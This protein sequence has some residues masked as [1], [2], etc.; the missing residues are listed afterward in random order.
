VDGREVWIAVPNGCKGNVSLL[1]ALRENADFWDE[2]VAWAA[3]GPA[4]PCSFQ[5]WPPV[6]PCGDHRYCDTCLNRG[7]CGYQEEASDD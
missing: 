4:A 1:A 2:C 6:A 5:L 7:D 3:G